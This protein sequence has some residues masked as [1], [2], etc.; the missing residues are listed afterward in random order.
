MRGLRVQTQSQ[1]P[2]NRLFAMTSL[3]PARKP[4]D[5]SSDSRTASDLAMPV[6]QPS[7]ASARQHTLLRRYAR[8]RIGSWHVLRDSR[9]RTY[10]VGS[11][12]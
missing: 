12:I 9:F 8:D 6:L 11:T 2:G 7:K 3:A 1:Q 4:S 5:K 10:F